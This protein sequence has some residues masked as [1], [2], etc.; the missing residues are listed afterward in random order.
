MLVGLRCERAADDPLSVSLLVPADDDS[1]AWS[2]ASARAVRLV[3]HAA[4]LLDAAGLRLEDVIVADEADVE[5]D[6]LVRFGGFDALLV[7]APRGRVLSSGPVGRR[8]V[9]APARTDGPWRHPPGC[10]SGELAEACLR[11]VGASPGVGGV[12]RLRAARLL[13]L[14]LASSAGVHAALAPAHA[15][16][17]P[18]LGAMFALAALTL[19]GW[20]CVD[21][22]PGPVALAAAVLLLCSL[23]V[24]YAA[25]RSRRATAA[26]ARRA[27][28]RPRRRHQAGRS[29]GLVLALRL[30]HT[31]A[32]RAT[33]PPALR[34]GAGP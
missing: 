5:V 31:P 29:G 7:C 2:E 25:T 28:R 14:A 33:A 12:N 1:G 15:A 21:R 11:P 16:E 18:L 26:H 34:E 27:G 22:A 19:A 20:R 8:P 4:T 9:G 30:L 13:V 23:L 32:G 10:R 3:G 17:T 6:R 24:A